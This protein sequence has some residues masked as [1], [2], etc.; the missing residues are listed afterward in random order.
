MGL[1]S[2]AAIAIA[3]RQKRFHSGPQFVQI[4]KFSCTTDEH[5]SAEGISFGCIWQNN[6][7]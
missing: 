6:R 2:Y 3:P 5:G 7:C 4:V 1:Y